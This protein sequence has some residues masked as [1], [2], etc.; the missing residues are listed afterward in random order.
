MAP[1]NVFPGVVCPFFVSDQ[2]L[3]AFKGETAVPDLVFFVNKC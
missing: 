1:G 2:H 3:F